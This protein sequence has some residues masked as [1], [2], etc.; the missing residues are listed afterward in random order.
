VPGLLFVL[1]GQWYTA[2]TALLAYRNHRFLQTTAGR[3][4]LAEYRQLLRLAE[5]SGAAMFSAADVV[6]VH[7]GRH[8]VMLDSC[9]FRLRVEAGKTDPA[10][11]IR[12]LQS[13]H[14]R[15]VVLAQDIRRHLDKAMYFR[16]PREVVTAVMQHYRLLGP[17]Q[18][19]FFVY[20]PR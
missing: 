3:Q 14:F 7:Q 9:L 16:L 17:P 8:A 12:R 19:G 13:Q 6:A 18:A 15:Y 10:E 4:W 1:P 11:L 5:D 2:H 20:V